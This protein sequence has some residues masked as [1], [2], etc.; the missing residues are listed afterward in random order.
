M[1]R[2]IWLKLSAKCWNKGSKMNSK[3]E[4]RD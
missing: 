1:R 3:Q 2:R 4:G